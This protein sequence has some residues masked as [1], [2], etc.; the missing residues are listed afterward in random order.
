MLLGITPKT[1]GALNATITVPLTDADR[2]GVQLVSS[3][4][5]G[6]VSFFASID[7]T[8]FVAL[9]MTPSTGA[10]VATTAT[11]AGLWSADVSAYCCVQITATAYTSGSMAALIAPAASFK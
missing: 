2:V 3:S 7:G 11:A 1:L 5:V 10:A 9:G 8:N 4:F 6:T